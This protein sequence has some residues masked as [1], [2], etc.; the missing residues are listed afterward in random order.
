MWPP[1]VTEPAT[2]RL[3]RPVAIVCGNR[4]AVVRERC[5]LALRIE[6]S[7]PR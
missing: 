3:Q 2:G 7:T 4:T 1:A 5:C 6:N